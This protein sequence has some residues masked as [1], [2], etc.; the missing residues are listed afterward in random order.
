MSLNNIFIKIIIKYIKTLEQTE[1]IKF[2]LNV[3]EKLI[4]NFYNKILKFS[5]LDIEYNLKYETLIDEENFITPEIFSLLEELILSLKDKRYDTGS[6]YTDKTLINNIFSEINE[7]ENKTILEPSC[8]TGN[9]VIFLL[10]K[11]IK[12][13]NNKKDYINYIEKYI[14]VNELKEESIEVYFKRLEFISINFFNEKFT[15]NDYNILKNNSFNKD[16]LLDFY[17]EKKFDVIIGNPPYLSS[18]SLGQEYLNKLKDKY[19]ISDDLYSLFIIKSFTLLNENYQFS[20]ITSNTYFT[21]QSKE[22]LRKEMIE[23]GLYKIINNNNNHFN[24]MTKTATFFISNKHI[25]NNVIKLLEEDN[26]GVLVE[27]NTLN[28]DIIA[29]SNFKLSLYKNE[30]EEI[31]NSF[32][33]S[34]EIFNKY[35]KNM[36]TSNTILEFSKTEEYL[37]IIKENSI[38]PLGL[39]CVIG[40]GIDFSG[41][42]KEILYSIDNKKFNIIENIEDIEYNLTTTDFRNGL[43]NKLFVKAIKGIEHLFVKWDKKTFNYLKS[44]K[45]PLRNLSFYGEEMLYCK[46]S[47]FEFTKIDKNTLCINT[48]GACFI[49]PLIDIDINLLFE[50]INKSELKE[51]IKNNINNSL[52]FT[53]NDLKLIP[54]DLKSII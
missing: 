11:L 53:P 54:L 4:E 35:S 14:F 34:I 10:L 31:N 8:G 50:M 45:A 13:F 51:Y 33:K 38:V 26:N 32:K 48:A 39:I 3:N 2:V 15:I 40:T 5:L 28:K 25:D 1:Q 43:E 7:L 6:Y 17:I 9:F 47:T 16:F 46:T 27:V 42:N 22:Y 21:L 37:K 20:F 12:N 29:K 49:K 36:T 52:G 23:K 44:I 18:K 30:N 19:A 41:K 24:I